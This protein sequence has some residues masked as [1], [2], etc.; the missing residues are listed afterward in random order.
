MGWTKRDLIEQAFAKI[1]LAGYVF[2][3]SAEQLQDALYQLDAMMAE[4]DGNNIKLGYPLTLTPG[5]A[6][7]DQDS[8]LP[9]YAVQAVFLNLGIRLGSDF[10]KDIPP[11]TLVAAKQGYDGLLAKAAFP[12]QQQLPGSM[13]RGAGQKPWRRVDDPFV[14]PPN[15]DPLQLD[16]SGNL[17]FS[18][19]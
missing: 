8:N 10:G 1:G 19:D 9:P 15:D 3:L 13:P 6:D 14:R 18:G 17:R 5:N 4:W 12:Q 7:L 16:R 2:D 11:R